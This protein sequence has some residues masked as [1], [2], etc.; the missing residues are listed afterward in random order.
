MG[1]PN[2]TNQVRL[3]VPMNSD[4][5][6]NA[7]SYLC[8]GSSRMTP[9]SAKDQNTN[10]YSKHQALLTATG[11]LGKLHDKSERIGKD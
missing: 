9:T 4:G 7:A 11:I 5:P 3:G 8:H 1:H 10:R 6:Y 2:P